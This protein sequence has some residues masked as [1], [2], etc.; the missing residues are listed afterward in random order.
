MGISLDIERA[1]E[2]F[3]KRALEELGISY[4]VIS[5][6]TLFSLGESPF[7]PVVLI[8]N[9]SATN[10]AYM[11]AIVEASG[12][13]AVNSSRAIVLGHDKLLTYSALLRRGL[14]IPKSWVALD[15]AELEGAG[16]DYPLIDKPPIGSWGRLVSLARSP[17]ALSAI[18]AQRRALPTPA[19][20]V[21][22]LQRPAELGRD[23]RCLV[24]G[25]R[26]VAC[27]ERRGREGEW[28]SN[29]AIGGSATALKPSHEVEELSLKAAEAVGAEVAG[30]D[31]L[32]GESL[33]VNEV[34][35]VP[36]FKALYKATGVNV[37]RAIAE[38]LMEL[39][40]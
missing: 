7:P 3:I 32:Y 28:R 31:L 29:A 17:E 40:R 35:V 10:S 24:V 37:A 20:R 26:V 4:E 5:S 34:N 38:Y 14:K 9:I 16:L 19:L 39:R 15:G 12:S 6:S 11:A 21:H 13:R 2:E 22:I 23:V 8:R 25:S 33:L 30:V 18:A 27:M 1:E 36:E